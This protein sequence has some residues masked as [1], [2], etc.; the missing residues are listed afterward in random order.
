MTAPGAGPQLVVLCEYLS[1][2]AD[3]PVV[4]RLE[5]WTLSGPRYCL[6]VQQFAAPDGEGDEAWIS[7]EVADADALWPLLDDWSSSRRIAEQTVAEARSALARAFPT[8]ARQDF[9]D[10][11]TGAGRSATA[12]PL[13]GLPTVPQPAASSGHGVAGGRDPVR[14]GAG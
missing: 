3:E 6:G 5:C 13:P 12:D 9:A 14:R 2:F 4:E 7:A 10:R 1:S 11:S 8:R